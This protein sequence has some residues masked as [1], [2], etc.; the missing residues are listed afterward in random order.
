MKEK[1][2]MKL[3]IMEQ[4]VEEGELILAGDSIDTSASPALTENF[5]TSFHVPAG[6]VFTKGPETKAVSF[7]KNEFHVA[8]LDKEE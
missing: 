7:S 6:P 4:M 1:I 3:A 8:E 5:S 2:L